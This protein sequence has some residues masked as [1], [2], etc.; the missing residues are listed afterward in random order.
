VPRKKSEH[1]LT[2]LRIR[3]EKKGQPYRRTFKSERDMVESLER[4]KK[5]NPKVVVVNK[6]E[7]E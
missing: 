7:E 3:G 2:V 5:Y 6:G 1:A 4:Y